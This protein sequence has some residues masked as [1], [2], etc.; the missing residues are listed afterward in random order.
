MGDITK[1][2]ILGIIVEALIEYV[3]LIF[4]NHSIN[5]KQV[6]A[7]VIGI[8]LSCCAQIDLF[9]AV[10]LTFVT[11]WVGIILTGVIFSRGANY[12]ADF[13]AL[14]QGKRT[15]VATVNED[16]IVVEEDMEA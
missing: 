6:A 15:S 3:K 8:V 9:A 5:W 1:I 16:E 14:I 12:V 7:L 13:V 10:G 11:P 2:I 4:V